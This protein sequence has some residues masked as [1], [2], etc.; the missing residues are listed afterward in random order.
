[1][2]H[3]EIACANAAKAINADATGQL[4]GASAQPI[5][6]FIHR[7]IAEASAAQDGLGVEAELLIAIGITKAGLNA[8]PGGI[9]VDW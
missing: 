6:A 5:V 4:I 3:V 8:M 2:P 7:D 9:A 1:M